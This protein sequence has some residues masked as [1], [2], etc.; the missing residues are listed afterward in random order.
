MAN[1][2]PISDAQVARPTLLTEQPQVKRSARERAEER[3]F[4]ANRKA[5]PASIAEGASD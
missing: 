3:W 4:G 1:Q 2:Y 5:A